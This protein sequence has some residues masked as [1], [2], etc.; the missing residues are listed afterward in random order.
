MKSTSDDKGSP[1]IYGLKGKKS[2]RLHSFTSFILT[3]F[4][5]SSSLIAQQ[6]H[7]SWKLSKQEVIDLMVG[8]SIQATRG[9]NSE[10]MIQRA[11][12]AF[13]EGKTFSIIKVEDLHDDWTVVVTCG[14][15]GGR[16]WEYVGE[17]LKLQDIPTVKSAPLKA[18]EALSKYLGKSFNALIRNEPA[19]STLTALLTASELGIPVVDA[20]LSGRARPEV[21]QQIPF[22][23]G[24][25]GT[26]S[27]MVTRWGDT[28]IVDKAIDDYRLEDL[29]RG[30]AVASGGAVWLAMNPMSGKEVKRGV[31]RGSLSQ[32]I[33]F[34]R[35]IREA[36]DKGKN[37]IDALVKVSNGYKLFHGV[38]TK[39]EH[40]G[41]R[42][43]HWANVE[44]EGVEEY[45]GHVYKVFVKNENIISWIDDM[46]D[47]M[48]PDHICNL[49][50]ET[51]D[52][53][54]E[55]GLKG[56]PVGQEIV[57]VGM[58]ASPLWRTRRGIEV[59][60]PRHFGFDFDYVPIE[61]LQERRKNLLKKLP[62]LLN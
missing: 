40:K 26:P 18:S 55:W 20:C 52:A 15:G 35:T 5:L 36:R 60:G 28:L 21:Q 25:P 47:V 10:R 19:G 17:R 56:Y 6:E 8:S 53:V 7:R 48:S 13:S 27:A 29:A 24:I 45:K 41:E 54:S 30:V 37:P 31:I 62:N 11:M 9:N 2:M 44:L 61:E 57:F 32:A 3:L 16:A 49:D 43:F 12:A 4:V 46:P 33:L 39:S 1:D 51:G 34:G 22:L 14:V 50:P 58:P 23:I 42:G 38:V 59:L